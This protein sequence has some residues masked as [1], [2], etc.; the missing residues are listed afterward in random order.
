MGFKKATKKK[1]KKAPGKKGRKDGWDLEGGT[2]TEDAPKSGRTATEDD[3]TKEKRGPRKTQERDE[4]IR[5][6]KAK[7][8]DRKRKW[9][10]EK[11]MSKKIS[12]NDILDETEEDVNVAEAPV[13]EPVVKRQQIKST[14]SVM[15]RLQNFV[16]TDIA[17]TEAATSRENKALKQKGSNTEEL[18]ESGDEDVEEEDYEMDAGEYEDLNGEEDGDDNIDIDDENDNVDDANEEME[19]PETDED[20]EDEAD[21]E[22]ESEDDETAPSIEKDNIVDDFDWL[23]NPIQKTSTSMI[24]DKTNQMTSSSDRNDLQKLTS[25]D[26]FQLY[27]SLHPAISS[28]KRSPIQRYDAFTL[29]RNSFHFQHSK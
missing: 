6:G 8:E 12:F 19:D 11:K 7:I 1:V 25:F 28:T 27:G 26:D 23:F 21:L 4:Y 16:N 2:F 9:Q 5:R 20:R 14:M 18:E 17:R 3:T 24:K 29:S 10:F 22:S 13:Y 15:E